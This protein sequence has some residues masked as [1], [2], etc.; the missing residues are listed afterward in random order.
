MTDSIYTPPSANL[1]IDNET[2]ASKAGGSLETGVL[3]E[4]TFT[5]GD[6]R[7]EAWRLVKGN[8]GAI[9]LATIVLS[10]IYL[11]AGKV[12]AMLGVPDGS[13]E[14]ASGSVLLGYG[15]ATFKGLL[16]IPV[17]APLMAGFYL[18]CIKRVVGIPAS[19]NELFAHFD[20][21]PNLILISLISAVMVYIGFA[22]LVLPGIYLSLAYAFAVPLMIDKKLTPWQS[23]EASR[24]AVTHNWFK[25]LGLGLL[26]YLI[27]ILSM[28]TVV[29]IIW[30]VP[31]CMLAYGVLYRTIF[32]VSAV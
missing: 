7:R 14:M 27:L 8:K 25:V 10:V 9:W 31:M 29:G 19:I 11:I 16:L 12:L 26:L 23:L 17:T 24:K 21:L 4:Y 32:G 1:T 18:L 22:L 30:T 15:I 13:K 5:I 20:K 2:G 3:G 28:F 6:V